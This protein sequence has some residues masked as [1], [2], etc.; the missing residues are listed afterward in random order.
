[1]LIPMVLPIVYTA[2]YKRQYVVEIILITITMIFTV[3]AYWPLTTV[4][5]TTANILPKFI[6]FVFI[7]FIILIV[8]WKLKNNKEN[9]FKLLGLTNNLESSLKLGLALIPLMILV[10]FLAK[11][12]IGLSNIGPDLE[13]GVVS[14]IESFSEEFFFRG[15]LFL[16]LTIRTNF[17]VAYITSL[18]SFILMHPQNLTNLFILST[19]VQGILTVEICRRTKNLTGAWV[20]HGTNRFFSIVILPFIL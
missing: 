12:M 19:I 4:L 14:F 17:K 5:Q 18:A 11:Y 6:L 2:L 15:I 10:T 9:H 20:L 3:F 13:L 8:Y 1:M 16:L 7:P